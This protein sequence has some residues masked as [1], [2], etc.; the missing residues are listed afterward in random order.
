M[1]EL[2]IDLLAGIGVIVLSLIW[3]FYFYPAMKKEYQRKGWTWKRIYDIEVDNRRSYRELAGIIW[4]S[5]QGK[6][7]HNSK[8]AEL[9]SKW[10]AVI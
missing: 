6:M 8:I 2:I 10:E 9:Y 5:N 4:T 3:Y 1:V 7:K